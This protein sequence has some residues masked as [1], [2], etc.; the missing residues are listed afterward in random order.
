MNF[1]MTRQLEVLKNYLKTFG[2]GSTPAPT[3]FDN[4]PMKALKNYPQTFGL[5]LNPPPLW[6]N[7]QK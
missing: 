4:V 7:V 2:M 5:G 6:E 3:L 1:I